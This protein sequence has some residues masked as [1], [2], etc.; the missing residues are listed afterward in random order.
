MKLT[1]NTYVCKAFHL[2]KI[3]G[4]N[5]WVSECLKLEQYDVTDYSTSLVKFYADCTSLGE[6]TRKKS[7][8]IGGK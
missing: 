6:L 5:G 1:S 3:L 2:P 4:V 7:P 8:K